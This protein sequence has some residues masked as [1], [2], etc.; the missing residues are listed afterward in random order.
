MQEREIVF[1]ARGEIVFEPC[2]QPE[3]LGEHEVRG[4][5]IATLVSPGTE[6]AWSDNGPFPVRP[7]YAAVFEVEAAGSAVSGVAQ[8]ERRLCMGPHRSFQQVDVRYT[9]PIEPHLAV[10][11]ALLA[12]LIGVSMT[13]LMTTRARPGDWVGIGGAGPV[14]YLAAHLF[15]LGGYRVFVVEPDA[16]RR[17]RVLASGIEAAFAAMPLDH[18]KLLGNVALMVDCSGHEQAVLDACRMVRQGGEVVLVGVPWRR[19][20]D[21]SAHELLDAVFGGFVHL[22]SGW[23]WEL[24]LLRQ[25]FRWEALTGG[26]NNSAHSILSGLT[27]AVRWLGEG[28][29][30]VEGLFRHA[31]P[32]HAGDIYGALRTGEVDPPFVVFDWLDAA[33]H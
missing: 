2:A 17:E 22:R 14:G 21:A 5:T 15:R 10:R 3:N 30:P 4:R 7:G 19:R 9:V 27:H 32:E 26:Y 20:S 28:R 31:N 24:P 23:E 16:V 18:A 12:R 11:E 33:A 8:G 29:F 25:P 13:T 1:P 6:L